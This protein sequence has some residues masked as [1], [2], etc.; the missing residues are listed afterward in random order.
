MVR[1]GRVELP[2]DVYKTSVLTGELIPH[3]MAPR[4]GLEPAIN[5]LTAGGSTIELSWNLK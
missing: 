4:A 2:L 1:D 5:R 3:K